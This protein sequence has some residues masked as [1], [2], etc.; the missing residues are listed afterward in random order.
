VFWVFGRPALALI[1]FALALSAC[2]VKGGAAAPSTSPI[3]AKPHVFIIVMEN[4]SPA[5]ALGGPYTSSLAKNYALLS[6]Y[7]AVSHPSLPNYLALTSGKTYG[8][9]DDG[10]YRLPQGGI[11]D[12]LTAAGISWRAYME[13]MSGDC[14]T[15]VGSY[16]LRHNPFAYYGGSCPADVVSLDQLAGDLASNTPQYSWISP[17]MCN[18]THDC[19]I[20][21]GDTWL[22]STVPQILASPAW[23]RNGVLFIVWDEAEDPQSNAVAALV[24]APK[25][26]AHTS[27]VAYDHYSLLATIEDLLG[28]RRLGNA[29]GAT[30]INDV[31]ATR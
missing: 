26:K 7:T 17:D 28:V 12:Q 10:Y 23:K 24:I 30:A 31:I 16:V 22:A 15:E 29:V 11:G 21:T 2:G 4:K 20:Q 14:M 8:V 6:N 27:A 1:V 9:T 13:G 18:D 19:P 3:V 25:L 5:Q